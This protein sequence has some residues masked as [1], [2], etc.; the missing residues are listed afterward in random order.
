MT[1]EKLLLKMLE[2]NQSILFILAHAQEL[3]LADWY[4]GAGCIS[5][6]IW[7]IQS[8]FE[9]EHAIKDYD[10]VYYDPV[11][12]SYEAED[13]IIQKGQELFKD[14][15]IPVEIRN[16]ARVHLWYE[17]HFGKPIEQY[18]S[19][20][21][22]ISTWPTTATCV[23]IRKE[24]DGKVKVFAFFG[25]DDLFNMIVRPNKK[26]ITEKIYRDKFTGWVKVWPKLKVIPWD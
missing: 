25:L 18:K 17:K 14:L 7:N 6:T 19:V 21:D 23:G 8:G 20:E 11:N 26:L 15:T 13:E 3:N 5:Q 2:K 1:K 10:L 12:I 16:E 9:P 22:A 24:L 4:L